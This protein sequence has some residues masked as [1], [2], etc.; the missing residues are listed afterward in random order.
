MHDFF[1][2]P[3]CSIIFSK[4]VPNFMVLRNVKTYYRSIIYFLEL[5]AE[6]RAR[7]AEVQRTMVFCELNIYWPGEKGI[8]LAYSPKTYAVLECE[9]A[10]AISPKGFNG[11]LGLYLWFRSSNLRSQH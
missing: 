1:Q 4:I 11:S 5:A 7:R 2:N 3:D 10:L 8:R 9:I 6:K